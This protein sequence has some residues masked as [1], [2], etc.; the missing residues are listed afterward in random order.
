MK[1]VSKQLT[2]VTLELSLQSSGV[3]VRDRQAFE[4]M[5]ERIHS[6]LPQLSSRD[7][8]RIIEGASLF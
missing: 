5:K 6:Q 8:L 7:T 3:L 2:Q 4:S 1:E